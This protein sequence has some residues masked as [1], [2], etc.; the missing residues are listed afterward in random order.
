VHSKVGFKDVGEVAKQL[1]N[2]IQKAHLEHIFTTLTQR[3]VFKTSTT[4]NLSTFQ[5]V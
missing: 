4:V 5:A 1:L 3:K 2:S